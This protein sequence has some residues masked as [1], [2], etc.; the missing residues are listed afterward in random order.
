MSEP[1]QY[2]TTIVDINSDDI[3]AHEH[4]GAMCINITFCFFI[5]GMIGLLIIGFASYMLYNGVI[6]L[7]NN[8]D[9]ISTLFFL[10]GCK[11]VLSTFVTMYLIATRN[12]NTSTLELIT[13]KRKNIIL[14]GSFFIFYD[15]ALFVLYILS[16]GLNK[17]SYIESDT[18]IFILIGTIINCID[19]CAWGSYLIKTIPK[20]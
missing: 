16:I 3:N 19:M 17:I 1:V 11:I 8:N 2:N 6:S 4:T 5:I 12:K 13:N 10:I 9:I 18:H 14:V 15:L 20:I 7:Y